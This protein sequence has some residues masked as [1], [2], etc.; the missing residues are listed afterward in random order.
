MT[1]TK[2]L[3]ERDQK[4]TRAFA[5]R[6]RLPIDWERDLE[7]KLLNDCLVI[8]GRRGELYFS[9]GKLCLMALNTRVSGMSAEAIRGLGG[10][11]WIGGIWRD[12]RRRGFRD[13]KVQ[14]IPEE[15]WKRA[16]ELCR[17][18]TRRVL[19]DDEKAALRARLYPERLPENPPIETVQCGSD[20]VGVSK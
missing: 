14:G 15:N 8:R 10:K 4:D 18:R 12:E 3:A 6:F 11:C 7:G 5:E 1:I 9:S 17:V 20:G 2:T 19:S 16:I 13:V